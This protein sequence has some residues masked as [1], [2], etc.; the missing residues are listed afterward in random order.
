MKKT[1]TKINPLM[2]NGNHKVEETSNIVKVNPLMKA[3]KSG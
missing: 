2:D 3:G 1:V